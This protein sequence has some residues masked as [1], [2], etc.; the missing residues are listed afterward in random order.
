MST[1]RSVPPSRSAI[2]QL[3]GHA[4][5]LHAPP[6]AHRIDRTDARHAGGVPR[7]RSLASREKASRRWAGKARFRRASCRRGARQFCAIENTNAIVENL[8]VCLN[9]LH[10]TWLRYRR[11]DV[12]FVDWTSSSFADIDNV[13][14]VTVIKG[15]EPLITQHTPNQ[16]GVSCTTDRRAAEA[17]RRS[18]NC[19]SGSPCP[20]CAEGVRPRPGPR[21]R[22]ARRC[23]RPE[24][25]VTAAGCVTPTRLERERVS[26]R[27]DSGQA[28]R[29][30]ELLGEAARGQ[31]LVAGDRD[32]SG[33]MTE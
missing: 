23:A 33:D 20:T 24:H 28:E 11:G 29:A 27:A 6:D 19:T 32:V 16:R 21:A 26:Q 8:A 4:T 7:V 15:G 2:F 12:I 14:I 25:A 5:C 1:T 17:R 30:G 10:S 31:V 22:R 13:G 9:L 3:P 18:T